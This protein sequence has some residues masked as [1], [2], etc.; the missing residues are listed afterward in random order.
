MPP[1]AVPVIRPIA[2]A[3]EAAWRRLWAGYLAFYRQLLAPEV[4][5]ATWR[6]IIG[7]DSGAMIGRVAALDGKVVG[8]LHAV[9]HA[10]TWSRAAVCYL[11]DLYVD[12]GARRCGVGRALIE[13]LA[14]EGRRAG[15]HRIYWRT[16]ADNTTAQTLYDRLARRSGWI[17]YELDL[18]DG[19]APVR[20]EAI[21]AAPQAFN[22][23]SIHPPNSRYSHGVVH[24]FAPKTRRLV[25]SGQVG[26]APD[27]TVSDDLATQV[28]QAWDNL[29]GVLAG[30]GM[31]PRDIVKVTTFV[32]DGSPETVRRCR[33]I[34]SRRLGEHAPASTFLVVAGLASP[35]FK[36]EIEAEAVA[37]QPPPAP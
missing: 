36:V 21:A 22:P 16:A 3:D 13:A 14:G 32:T 11:E 34:R 33:E 12:A 7:D 19:G 18:P 28:E 27:G 26:I 2:P 17:T 31:G 23:P 24:A 37:A 1:A 6:R 20:G 25:I 9:I 30:A 5:E 29:F 35:A 15:W 10:N 8:L 4:T